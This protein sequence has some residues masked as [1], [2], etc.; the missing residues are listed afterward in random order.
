MALIEILALALAPVAFLFTLVYLSDRYEREPLRYLV[1]SFVLGM[2]IAVPVVLLGNWLNAFL[3]VSGEGGIGELLVYAFV[4][5]ALTEEGMK[6]LVL[7]WY[8]YPH[9]EFDEPYDGIMYAVAVSLGFAAI[10]NVLYVL[11]SEGIATGIVRMFT[12]VPAHATF[13]VLMGYFVGKA[14]FGPPARALGYRLLGLLSAVAMHGFYDFFLFL[15]N[16]Y[17]AFFSFFALGAGLLL[18]RRAML[19][20]AS[21]S[22]HRLPPA[23]TEDAEA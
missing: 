5:V 14:K 3:G 12:A 23:D 19:L 18:A 10:E 8:N 20:H 6:Y 1:V 21:I 2:L 13:G 15:A 17:L 16:T 22:P 7:R 9:R 11:T 4:V